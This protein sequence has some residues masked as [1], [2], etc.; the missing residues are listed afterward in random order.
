[1]N[2]HY[3]M[4]AH[5]N[6]FIHPESKQRVLHPFRKGRNELGPK[7]PKHLGCAEGFYSQV[8]EDGT[9][10]NRLDTGLKISENLTF[11]S[12]KRDCGVLARCIYD[13]VFFP[14]TEAERIEIT[15]CTA[16]SYCRAPVQIHNVA[17][18]HQFTINL[19]TYEIG[20]EPDEPIVRAMMQANK[21]SESE[22]REHLTIGKKAIRDGDI[23][24]SAAF[25]H[26]RQSGFDILTMQK[27]MWI[28]EKMQWRLL[29]AAPGS[30]FLTSDN[31]VV[32]EDASSP[33]RRVHALRQSKNVEIWFPISHRYGFLMAWRKQGQGRSVA[34]H[35]QTRSLNRRM[36]KWCYRHVYS[37]LRAPWI[38]EAVRDVIFSPLLGRLK[39][40]HE[41][42]QNKP[43]GPID[44]VAALQDAEYADVFEDLYMK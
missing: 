26:E 13:D 6:K 9:V 21:M 41:C 35:S 11:G 39:S 37:P 15:H 4:V 7:G 12:G 31:P 2:D 24:V 10:T 17:M 23:T 33:T 40:I 8:L 36:I 16:F 3:V 5:L 29:E 22:A 43:D 27:E 34:S 18:M 14:T 19:M 42:Y 1:M 32:V 44:V 25:P 38:N 28:I 20:L 30:F